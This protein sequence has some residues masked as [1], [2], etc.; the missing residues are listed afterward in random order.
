MQ[1]YLQ[2]S[3]L[4]CS[5]RYVII[6]RF[7]I[8]Q[9]SC[10]LALVQN[11]T[12]LSLFSYFR[13]VQNTPSGDDSA[14]LKVRKFLVIKYNNETCTYFFIMIFFH[15]FENKNLCICKSRSIAACIPSLFYLEHFAHQLCYFKTQ[16]NVYK[17]QVML[18]KVIK[19]PDSRDT[20]PTLK[21]KNQKKILFPPNQLC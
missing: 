15:P 2:R 3:K 20:D 6:I 14:H 8:S 1:N 16:F 21:T 13:V 4:I 9:L 19:C 17:F 7:I 10:Q 5:L 12:F 18:Y 11:L